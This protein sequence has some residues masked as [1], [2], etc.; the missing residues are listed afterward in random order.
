MLMIEEREA[1]VRY[2]KRLLESGYVLGS[3]GNISLIDRAEG[4]VAITPSGLPYERMNIDDIVLLDLDGNTRE[5]HLE[6]S[7]E[8]QLHLSLLAQRPDVNAV[9]HTHS[10]FATAVACLGWDLPSFHYL[11]AVSGISIPCAPYAIYG[12]QQ[13]A[14]NV[15]NVIGNGKA[16]LM[17]NHGLVAVADTLAKAFDIAEIVEYLSC[18]YLQTRAVGHPQLLSELDMT[19]VMGKFDSYGNQQDNLEGSE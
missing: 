16:V 5:G 17:A 15:C 4:L 19:Q 3:G 11:V 12:S 8:Y 18:V 9:V 13:L 10:P 1:L 14:D 7:S 2:G 6:P